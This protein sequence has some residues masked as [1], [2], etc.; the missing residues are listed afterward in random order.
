NS[1]SS[2]VTVDASLSGRWVRVSNVAGSDLAFSGSATPGTP[3]AIH[4]N[5]SGTDEFTVAQVNGY[6][7]T[8]FIH[9]YVKAVLPAATPIDT[10]IICIVNID[11]GCN[12]YF[13][14]NINFFRAEGGCINT[15]Y[16][17]VVHHEYGHNI[18]AQIGGI[19]D[20][21]LSEGWGDIMAM[22]ATGQPI[23]GECF[24]G[25]AGSY[26]RTGENGRRWPA[27]EC[28]GEVH[29]LG[30]TWMGFAW[31][32]RKNLIASLGGPTGTAV[33]EQDVLN[34]LFANSGNIPDAVTEVFAQDDDNGDFGDGTPH[35]GDIR[36]AALK[37][38]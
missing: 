32:V 33:A 12:A 37:R 21:G 9:D 13:N 30:E 28:G 17:T 2:P 18:D 36:S 29:C 35:F 23:V 3:L 19:T 20:G 8:N 26:I 4:F 11:S 22:F 38:N 10:Q 34:A 14:G 1:G 25:S 16:D 27:S 24:F 15:S 31:D 5:P 6:F 7:Q